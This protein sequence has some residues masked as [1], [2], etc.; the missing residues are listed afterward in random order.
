MEVIKYPLR[1]EWAELVKRPALDVTTLFDT[2]RTVL[3]EVRKE[4][5]A[6]VIRYE[7]KFDKIDPATFTA[8]QASEV[9]LQEAEDLVSD[10]LKQAICQAKENIEIFHASQRFVGK[11]VETTPGVT[12]W[13]KAV[14]IE[15]VGLYVPGGTAPLFS[16][17]LML[18]IPARIAGCKE[19]VLCTPPNREG[20]VHPAILFAAKVAGVSKIFKTGG[21]QAIAAMAY[22]TQSV[23][24]VYKIFGPGNQYVTAAKQLVSLKEV[25]IDMPAGPSE[26]EVIADESANPAFI[27]ADFL[28][29]AEHGVDSQAMLVT[30]SEGI[31]EPVKQAI[32]EQLEQLPRKEITEKSLS[33]SRIVVLKSTEEVVDF[34]NLYAPEHLIIQTTNYVEIA[35][36]VENAGS[37][38][39]GYYTPESAGDYASGTNHTLPTNGYA[40]AYSGVNLDSFIKKITFQEITASGIKLLGNTIQTMAANEQLDAHKNAVTIRLNT[41]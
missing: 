17:V 19:I 14:A 32:Q 16:T 33:H 40:K 5:D 13:Q 18:A 28:S 8:L 3:D 7:E 25:A 36:Q 1:E 12:C 20:R 39:M 34:T 11:K 4:G 23:P 24:K 21:I 6:A 26:V 27:A 30:A 22:G 37:V 35:E 38:F 2:V 10:D 15:K 9:E 31:V 29:Q 41:L